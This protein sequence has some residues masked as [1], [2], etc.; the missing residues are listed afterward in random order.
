G[1]DESRDATLETQLDEKRQICGAILVRFGQQV[2]RME[3]ARR[4]KYRQ[5]APMEA[6]GALEIVVPLGE[7]ESEHLELLD[8]I[9]RVNGPLHREMHIVHLHQQQRLF[10][11]AQTIRPGQSRGSLS[12]IEEVAEILR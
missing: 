9:D 10:D 6:D 12:R 5:H 2:E 8:G 1:H 3:I 7:L 4:S 11:D